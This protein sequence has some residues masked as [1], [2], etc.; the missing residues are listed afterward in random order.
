MEEKKDSLAS[1]LIHEVKAQSRRK[2]LIILVIIVL[3]FIDQV[4]WIIAWNLPK[5][6][7]VTETESYELQGED[8]ANV[9]FNGDGEV[10]INEPDSSN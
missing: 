3:F 10:H 5:Q 6:E 9:I 7:Q 8:D 4:I 2:D 1:E